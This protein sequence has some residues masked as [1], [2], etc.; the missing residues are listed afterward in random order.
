[1]PYILKKYF[2]YITSVTQTNTEL[3]WASVQQRKRIQRKDKSLSAAHTYT[4]SKIFWYQILWFWPCPNN[5]LYIPGYILI[6]LL[7]IPEQ[8]P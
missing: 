3:R 8:F 1:M 5:F 7:W 4:S 6:F 2:V